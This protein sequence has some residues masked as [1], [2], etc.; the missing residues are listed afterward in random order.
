MS[1]QL[2]DTNL[3]LCI[4]DI[5]CFATFYANPGLPTF[6]IQLSD[7]NVTR[8]TPFTLTCEAVGPPNPVTIKW[9]H[10]GKR[11]AERNE[12]SSTITIEGTNVGFCYASW[13]CFWTLFLCKE[14]QKCFSFLKSCCQYSRESKGLKKLIEKEFIATQFDQGGRFLFTWSF[15]ENWKFYH[16][17]VLSQVPVETEWPFSTLC[18]G[19]QKTWWTVPLVNQDIF[20]AGKH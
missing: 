11:F 7:V 20:I 17:V 13:H 18:Y 9:L 10:T 3:W 15:F 1:L 14:T 8:N 19:W 5:W 12:S 2:G 16:K 6:I 4:L